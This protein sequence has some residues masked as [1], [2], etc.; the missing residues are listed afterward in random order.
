MK[1]LIVGA[2]KMGTLHGKILMELGEQVEFVDVEFDPAQYRGG[3]ESI[4]ICTPAGTHARIIGL[5]PDIPIFCEKPL[6]TKRYHTVR[7]MEKSLV[8]CNW[9]WCEC[10]KGKK[11][12]VCR[13]PST[14]A[15]RQ[16]DILHFPMR[17]FSPL[18]VVLCFE[19]PYETRADG[20]IIHKNG[21]CDMFVK[22]MKHWLDVLKGGKSINTFNDSLQHNRDYLDAAILPPNTT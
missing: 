20:K 1:H 10:I 21:P 7:P 11:I 16:M 15:Y 5:L 22:Q 17:L 13:Y 12:L 2:G 18:R 19:P 9:H 8:A 3:H 4:L 14:C 6:I